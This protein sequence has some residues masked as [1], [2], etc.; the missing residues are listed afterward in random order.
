MFEDG[1]CWHGV[2]VKST[3]PGV[4]PVI[5]EC[6]EPAAKY[7]VTRA[8]SNFTAWPGKLTMWL[9]RSHAV[10]MECY[11]YTVTKVT[12]DTPEAGAIGL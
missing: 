12:I 4:K 10:E 5:R 6:G 9:C 8:T 7:E 11:G 2:Q 1:K 3:V